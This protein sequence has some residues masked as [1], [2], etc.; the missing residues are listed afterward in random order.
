MIWNKLAK[1]IFVIV[2][3]LLCGQVIWAADSAGNCLAS[4]PEFKVQ[5]RILDLVLT[6]VDE[7]HRVTHMIAEIVNV[8][9]SA[10]G[11]NC[12][13]NQIKEALEFIQKNAKQVTIMVTPEAE[14]QGKLLGFFHPFVNGIHKSGVFKA[15]STIRA[16]QLEGMDG[17]QLL[18]TECN[19]L[20]K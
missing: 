16:F 3:V 11:E 15:N 6:K 8:P 14:K 13:D 19:L 12:N 9:D 7:K 5:V 20:D 18:M 10:V 1:S 17:W 4:V 2:L